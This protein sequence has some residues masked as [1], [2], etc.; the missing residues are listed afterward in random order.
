MT[1]YDNREIY[2]E[3]ATVIHAR[4]RLTHHEYQQLT[5]FK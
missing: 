4:G 5:H 1:V 3:A 2:V